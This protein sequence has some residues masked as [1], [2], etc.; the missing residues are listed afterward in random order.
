MSDQPPDT[1]TRGTGVGRQQLVQRQIATAFRRAASANQEGWHGSQTTSSHRARSAVRK[2]PAEEFRYLRSGAS[3]QMLIQAL[4]ASPYRSLE[5]P[6]GR[7]AP[8]GP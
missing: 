2:A 3:G 1:A 5:I 4:Q 6:Q 8:A 7:D